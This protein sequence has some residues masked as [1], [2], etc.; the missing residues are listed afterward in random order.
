[1]MNIHPRHGV[2]V[3]GCSLLALA[4]PAHAQDRAEPAQASAAGAASLDGAIVVT[5][6]RREERLMDVPAAVTVVNA[7]TLKAKGITAPTD[8]IHAVPSLQQ[9]SSGFG[10]STPHFIIRG[11]RQ[12]LEFIQSDQ[13]V[14][15]YVDEV[16]VPRQQGLNSGLFDMANVQVLKGPQGTLFGKNQT[17]GAILFTSQAPQPD[18]GGFISATAGNYDA[19]RFEGAINIPL[20]DDLQVRL[21]GLMNRRDGYVHNVTD[22][23]DYNDTHTNGWRVSV[24]YAP[25]GLPIENSLIVSGS[26][27]EEIGAI[28]KLPPSY[29][30]KPGNATLGYFV[31]KSSLFTLF[32]NPAGDAL[33]TAA[34]QSQARSYGKWESGGVSQYQLP[35]GNNVDIKTFSVTNKTELSLGDTT[36]LRNIFGYRYL[37]SYQSSN[38]GGTAGFLLTPGTTV[39]TVNASRLVAP[40]DANGVPQPAGN[41]VCG[42]Q[43]GFDCVVAG[44]FDS[45]N[46]TK[47]RQ[48]SEELTLVGKA[49]DT[50]LDYILGAYYFR[51][52]GEGATSNFTPLSVGSRMGTA[53]NRPSNES[54]AVFGQ[55]TLHVIDAIAVTAGLRQTWDRR[56]TDSRSVTIVPNYYPVQGGLVP[57]DGVLGTCSLVGDSGTLP[58]NTPDNP[59]NCSFK[60]TAKFDQ[61]TYTF[62]VDWHPTPDMLV[63]AATRK[64]YRSGGFNQSATVNTTA[65]PTVLTPF[66][67]E[68]VTD[69]EIGFKGNWRF[70]GGMG[71]G[72]NL[73]LY[74]NNY[75]DIQRGLTSVAGNKLVTANAADATIQGLEVEA[76]FEPTHWLELSGYYSYVDAKFKTFNVPNNGLFRDFG[77][78]SKARFSGVP[79]HSG[80]ATLTVHGDVP[81]D[82]GRW[83]ASVD[84]YGQTGVYLQDNNYNASIQA[85]VPAQYMPAYWLL[86]LNVGW[87]NVM[88][89]PF[90]ASFNIRN[91]MK[92][93]YYSGGVDA[94]GSGIGTTA[95]FLGEP[96]LVT[97]NL[98]YHF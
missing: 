49:F 77:D 1:M 63:Y 30:G 42:P 65:Q 66:R 58:N 87:T 97:F 35:N 86:G 14:G 12:Y 19:R 61:L 43:S 36:T 68:T 18:F 40:L 5:A 89:R 90:D 8:L 59:D 84:Y 38:M 72:L 6:R 15:V 79:K 88:G 67:P 26:S 70:A 74:R 9:T 83:S 2:L 4:T 33:T 98:T 28:T 94:S 78:F 29:I 56:K 23:R 51:E 45:M 55:V 82:K 71:A 47:V 53:Q 91:L 11:Q 52:H 16:V 46:Y 60:G 93:Q 95:F 27:Q 13:S 37:N 3:A 69:Y 64:G 73:A 39:A 41:I 34:I 80:S 62:S 50:R 20:S 24:H 76:R 25:A 22:G 92:K 96:R 21:A 75:D 81:D 85:Y 44:V 31:G 57:A 32:G 10:N 7:E 54:K 48:V 17:G